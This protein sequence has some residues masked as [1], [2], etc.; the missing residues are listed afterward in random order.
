MLVC[1][2]TLVLVFPVHRP[3]GVCSAVHNRRCGVGGGGGGHAVWTSVSATCPLHLTVS[4]LVAACAVWLR[5]GKPCIVLSIACAVIPES[6]SLMGGATSQSLGT[7]L[8]M[9]ARRN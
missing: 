4:L 6:R 9:P 3:H 1:M 8:W 2:Y 5:K 7:R